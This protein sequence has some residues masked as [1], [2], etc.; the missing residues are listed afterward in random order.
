M[1]KILAYIITISLACISFAQQIKGGGF[2]PSTIRPNET[3]QYTIILEGLSGSVNPS[4]IPMPDGLQIVDTFVGTSSS[5]NIS[6]TNVNM[7]TQTKLIFIVRASKEGK[8]TVPEWKLENFKIEPA[9]LVVDKNAPS[10]QRRQNAMSILDVDDMFGFPSA[11]QRIRNMQRAQIQQAQQMQQ[12]QKSLGALKDYVSLKIQMPKEKIFVG[13]AIQ[14]KL[15]FSY[16]KELVAEGI[17]LAKLMPMPNKS[18]AFDCTL[19]EDKYSANTNDEHQIT[20]S[21]DIIITPLKAGSYNL[22]FNAQGVFLQEYQM[23]SFFGMPFGNTRQIPF[24]ISTKDTKV[25]VLP[26]PEEN[27]PASFSGA[28]GKFSISDVKAEPDSIEDGEPTSVSLN[29]IGMGNFS[30]VNAP[31]IKKS[32]D[33]KTYRPKNSFT[34]E[35]NGMGYIGIK[36]FKYTVVPTKPDITSTPDFEFSYFDPEKS[37]YKTL[38]VKG[39]SVSV[40]PKG[41]TVQQKV[42]EQQK[43]QD[44]SAPNFE[45]IIKTKNAEGNTNLFSSPLFWA[46]QALILITVIALI[47]IRSRI[48]T[49]RNNP[50]LARKLECK[51]RVVIFL[52]NAQ[53]SVEAED[54]ETFFN[55]ARKALQNAVATV[56][57]ICESSSITLRQAEEILLEQGFDSTDL[58]AVAEIFNGSDALA[59]GGLQDSDVDLKRL[60]SKLKKIC[61]QLK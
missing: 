41:K 3:A 18:D 36:N 1:K 55:N 19:L 58:L 6:I 12:Q 4:A 2:T 24:E 42:V 16:K 39:A 43:P 37:E 8:F 38:T 13:E 49:L 33:W 14:C 57:A 28:I 50:E 17:K 32:P 20:I 56:S 26:L 25:N 27:K 34:D 44:P 60:N 59:F 9:T 35:S 10:Q 52:K 46:I 22:D 54:A 15:V 48:N 5:G 29:I 53:N 51:K 7:S 21:Y 23:D 30:R 11:F 47:V 31:E 61:A 40:A 45:K